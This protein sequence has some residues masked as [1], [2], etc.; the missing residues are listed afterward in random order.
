MTGLFYIFENYVII[1]AQ[2]QQPPT[3]I[4]ADTDP[5]TFSRIY[6]LLNRPEMQY[7]QTYAIPLALISLVQLLGFIFIV[8]SCMQLM[9][10]IFKGSGT[11]R[12]YLY[13]LLLIMVPASFVMVVMVPL[14]K[15]ALT[16]GAANTIVT[17]V[18]NLINL[19]VILYA[20]VLAVFTTRHTHRLSGWSATGA[21]V[22]GYVVGYAVAFV[23]VSIIG[24]ISK[25]ILPAVPLF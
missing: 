19:A 1:P 20:L 5:T 10:K 4:P 12:H 25:S 17:S 23:F 22:V 7:H 21:V 14:T 13:N 24:S 8:M 16:G 3:Q 15:Y 11:Y 18:A 6:I 2:L 9:A